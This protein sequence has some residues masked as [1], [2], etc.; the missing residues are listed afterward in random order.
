MQARDSLLPDREEWNPPQHGFL[1]RRLHDSFTFLFFP[2]LRQDDES[3]KA[4]REE[5]FWFLS[6]SWC[7][8]PHELLFFPF[9]LRVAL[10][11]RCA[12]PIKGRYLTFKSG[13]KKSGYT[14]L[15]A[16]KQFRR[17]IP[18]SIPSYASAFSV[19]AY[20][21]RDGGNCLSFYGIVDTYVTMPSDEGG[22]NTR[23]ALVAGYDFLIGRMVKWSACR[24]SRYIWRRS[25]SG[26][27][28]PGKRK[29]ILC[30]QS[31]CS[32]PE[33]STNDPDVQGEER[34]VY[35]LVPFPSPGSA[36]I[37]KWISPC[38]LTWLE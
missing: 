1:F 32:H 14:N 36:W 34:L 35:P 27:P 11:I 33:L 31:T 29:I 20:A 2:A 5:E 22:E 28:T 8:T 21:S 4:G 10:L 17:F 19:Y 13:Y 6:V 15:L 16:L 7:A 38:R 3:G 25:R 24:R 30:W 9:S 37:K 18:H 12:L 26:V 23:I